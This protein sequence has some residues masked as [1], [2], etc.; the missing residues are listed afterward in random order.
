MQE[1]SMNHEIENLVSCGDA[2]L[3]VSL[4]KI[5]VLKWVVVEVSEFDR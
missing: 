1:V 2:Q 3:E 4:S 5:G